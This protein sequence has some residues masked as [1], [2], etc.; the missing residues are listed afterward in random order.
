MLPDDAPGLET[1][2][3]DPMNPNSILIALLALNGCCVKSGEGCIPD[4]P[5]DY[6]DDARRGSIR[7]SHDY[8]HSDHQA[9]RKKDGIQVSSTGLEPHY[10]GRSSGS[11]AGPPCHGEHRPAAMYKG[12]PSG[13]NQYGQWV[14]C[15]T[16]KLRLSY[17]PRAG[18]HG[19]TRSP[20][21]L[22]SDVK[23][24]TDEELPDLH[25][26]KDKEIGWAA[27]E[28]SAEENLQRIRQTRMAQQASQRGAAPTGK[29]YH[30]GA[31]GTTPSTSPPTTTNASEPSASPTSTDGS[32][33]LIHRG[34]SG[35]VRVLTTNSRPAVSYAL[36]EDEKEIEAKAQA[37]ERD[38]SFT[39][40][41]IENLLTGLRSARMTSRRSFMEKK[42]R[43]SFTI[44]FGLY[45]HGSQAGVM[46]ATFQLPNFCRYLNRWM[47]AWAPPDAKWTTLSLI[48]NMESKPHRDLHNLKQQPNYLI[49]FGEH[50]QGELWLERGP[51]EVAHGEVRRRQKPTGALA[52]SLQPRHR[53]VSFLS[54]RWHATMPWKGNKI[55]LAAY[56]ARSFRGMDPLLRQQLN[57]FGFPMLPSSTCL[58]TSTTRTE[59]DMDGP[60]LPE[61]RDF[62]EILSEN[63]A[64]EEENEKENEK[65]FALEVNWTNRAV[66]FGPWALLKDAIW[67]RLKDLF[68]LGT[69]LLNSQQDGWYAMFLSDLHVK[70]LEMI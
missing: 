38:G 64:V 44:G 23:A 12:S 32:A 66:R 20:G 52:G 58:T 54:D 39:I 55:A 8:L 61:S 11:H 34:G 35:G 16:C 18:C 47:Q 5:Y 65:L 27:A 56:T 15:E 4:E 51:D 22:P 6:E 14:A 63:F 36:L 50:E 60:N 31:K 59:D 30:K 42:V 10:R 43:D 41:D 29:G 53:V 70:V 19:L 68:K 25:T 26:L 9:E 48:V 57:T 45:A 1:V 13:S 46:N 3:E 28:K 33:V 2:T 24:A 69:W 7:E 21:A 67:E 40:E 49:T 62:Q 17:T 37:L